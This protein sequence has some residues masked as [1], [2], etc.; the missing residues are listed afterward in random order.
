[1]VIMD[2]LVHNRVGLEKRLTILRVDRSSGPAESDVVA[3]VL[4]G[5]ARGARV[6]FQRAWMTMRWHS[7]SRRFICCIA[8]RVDISIRGSYVALKAFP[9]LT[10]QR[11]NS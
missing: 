1:M 3:T 8:A 7:A 6:Q 2:I 5:D 11:A 4:N 9:S 10:H